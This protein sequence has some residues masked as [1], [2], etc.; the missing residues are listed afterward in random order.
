MEYVKKVK[1]PTNDTSSQVTQ[2]SYADFITPQVSP[3]DPNMSSVAQYSPVPTQYNEN[4]DNQIGP[5]VIQQYVTQEG[6]NDQGYHSNN[7]L[8]NVSNEISTVLCNSELRTSEDQFFQMVEDEG[9]NMCDSGALQL[10]PEQEQQGV[11]LLIT[12]HTTGISYSV[13]TQE[14]LVEPCLEE[15]D[16]QLL[17][18]ITPNPILESDLLSLDETT[19]KSELNDSSVRSTIVTSFQEENINSYMGSFTN[20]AINISISDNKVNT[21]SNV[22]S[23]VDAEEELCKRGI[24]F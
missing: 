13:N 23:K 16:Q 18:A 2:E 11:E 20:Q 17:E 3:L 24:L 14:L 12:D 21:R 19:L 9:V 10:I 8:D 4:N 15:D 6:E 7:A 22:Q 5:I 1:S